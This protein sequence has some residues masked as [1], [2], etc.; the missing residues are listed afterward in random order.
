[1]A[2]DTGALLYFKLSAAGVSKLNHA[3]SSGLPVTV[4]VHDSVSGSGASRNITLIPYS[5]AGA[6]PGHSASQSPTIQLL[7]RPGFVS[8]S[9][10]QGQLLAACYASTPC[11]VTAVVSANGQRVAHTTAE[12]LGVDELGV[13]YFKLSS[14]GRSM[15]RH[16]SGNQLPVQVKLSDRADTATG[17]LAL[18]GYR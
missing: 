7:Q 18:V 8:S 2:R 5:V 6:A 16:A 1:V 14:A 4:S 9:N 13:L 3:S 10:G 17:N 15:L 12:H 11:Q